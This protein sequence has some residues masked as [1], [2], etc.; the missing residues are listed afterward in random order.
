MTRYQSGLPLLVHAALILAN[1]IFGLGS[2]IG[3]LGLPETNPLAFT[4]IREIV[5]GHLLLFLSY[6]V[7]VKSRQHSQSSY[8]EY[9]LIVKKEHLK[10]FFIL[11]LLLFMNQ[12]VFIGTL[13]L[14]DK[15][16]AISKPFILKET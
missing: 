2:I 9:L 16:H 14:G 6:Y 8:E 10:P 15:A 7:G 4:A 1:S 12:S 13:Q 3:A 5:A 11:A